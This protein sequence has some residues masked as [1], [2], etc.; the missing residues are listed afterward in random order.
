MTSDD[1]T[2]LHLLCK[3]R[4]DRMC[5][6]RN[7]RGGLRREKQDVSTVVTE[8]GPGRHFDRCLLCYCKT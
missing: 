7:L 6:F 4:T 1:V 8:S 3:I 5:R 2:L